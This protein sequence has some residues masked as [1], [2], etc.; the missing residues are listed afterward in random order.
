MEELE[1]NYAD[2]PGITI[3]VQGLEGMGYRR[4]AEEGTAL[5]TMIDLPS[6]TRLTTSNVEHGVTIGEFLMSDQL[7]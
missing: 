4:A 7:K 2:P 6:R 3:L 5:E 1:L